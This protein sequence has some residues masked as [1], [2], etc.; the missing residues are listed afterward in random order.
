FGCIEYFGANFCLTDRIFASAGVKFQRAA[1]QACGPTASDN[2]CR[3]GI[4]RTA[5]GESSPTCA[6]TCCANSDCGV[7]ICAFRP[8]FSPG[9]IT[10]HVCEPNLT[11]GMQGDVCQSELDCAAYMC[12]PLGAQPT[13]ADTC[14]TSSDCPGG[15]YCQQLESGPSGSSNA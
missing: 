10:H 12:I 3:S 8:P 4:C 14:C 7:T 1:G 5:S 9:E 13:C 6:A 2:W 15:T 11:A